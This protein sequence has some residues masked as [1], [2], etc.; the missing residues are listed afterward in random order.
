MATYYF[1]GVAG[2]SEAGYLRAAGVQHVLVDPTDLKNAAGFRH[3]VLDS[4]AYRCFKR[5]VPLDPAAYQA[6]ARRTAADWHLAPD[7]IGNAQATE[8][9]WDVFRQP[10]MV[11]VW[12]FGSERRLLHKYL[13]T[14]ERVAIGGLVTR[15]REKDEAMLQEV[16]LLCEEFPHRF[17][18]LGANWLR[19]ACQLKDVISSLDS[20][21]W[22]VGGRYGFV[23]F[24]NT[25]SRQ[26]QRAPA[27]ALGLA[28]LTRAERNIVCAKAINAFF[29][30]SLAAPRTA[31]SAEQKVA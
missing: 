29:N 13:D 16:T 22:L 21:E 15:M 3:V 26:L 5:G 24:L 10:S 25:R 14:A 20:A 6:F 9:N 23:V 4:G 28:H 19:A 27:R 1:S 18:V 17:H 31:E 30:R 8:W 7:V 2:A 11:P 12:G